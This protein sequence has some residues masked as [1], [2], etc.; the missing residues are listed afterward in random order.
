MKKY[1][2]TKS[3]YGTDPATFM[4]DTFDLIANELEPDEEATVSLNPEHYAEPTESMA[5]LAPESGLNVVSTAEVTPDEVQIQVKK[6][7]A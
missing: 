1:D 6:R 7:A 4:K 2:L 3:T 5:A